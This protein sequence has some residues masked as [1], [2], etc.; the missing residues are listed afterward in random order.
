MNRELITVIQQIATEKGIDTEVLFE[1]LESALESAFKKTTGEAQ[2]VRMELS[3]ETGELKVFARKRVVAK[4]T[5][6]RSELTLEEGRALVPDIEIDEEI[7]QELAP[8]EFGRIAAQTAK[9]VILQ[10]VRDAEREGIYSEFIGKE[11]QIVRGVVHRIEK[12]NVIVELGKAEGL[13]PE[14]EQIPGE[15]I[16]PGDRVRSLVLEVRKTAKGPQ[17]TLSRTHPG[18]LI[19][20]FETEIPEIAERIVQVKAAAREPGERAK[21]AVLSTKRDV[22]PIGACVGLRGTRIQVI[23][24]EIRGEKID[25]VE[26]SSDLPTFV[27]RALSPARVSSVTVLEEGGEGAGERSVLVV[28]P[29]N[30]LSLA[31]GKKGQNARLAAKLTGMRVDIK[32]ESELEEE[33]RRAEEERIEGRAAIQEFEGVGPQLADKLV[34]KGLYSPAR[35]VGGG[36]ERLLEVPGIGE[37]KAEKILAAAHEWLT[38]HAPAATGEEPGAAEGGPSAEEG[39]QV[40][41]GEEATPSA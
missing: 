29:D 1:A 36:V 21:V 8:R 35:I 31:I 4:V 6:P 26:W 15:R 40:L 19:R 41:R 38:A 16:N 37:K 18:F 5:D 17:I 9:Q 23:S 30:Q 2:D 12:R 3:R 14:R 25:I 7:E 28:V 32:S 22:D 39:A 24:R 20:L 13:L 33:R 34:D 11:G 10:R 27:A